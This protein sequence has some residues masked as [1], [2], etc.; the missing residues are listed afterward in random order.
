MDLKK[1][2]WRIIFSVSRRVNNAPNSYF[3]QW[4]FS[5]LPQT[6]TPI[7]R[8][9]RIHC[10]FL[11]PSVFPIVPS[12]H[13]HWL[14]S[15]LNMFWFSSLFNSWTSPWITLFQ[16]NFCRDLLLLRSHLLLLLWWQLR[17]SCGR[18][19]PCRRCV[20]DCHWRLPSHWWFEWHLHWILQGSWWD[21]GFSW[22]PALGFWVRVFWWDLLPNRG[23][24]WIEFQG[25][26]L[27]I[28]KYRLK[29]LWRL[30]ST[31]HWCTSKFQVFSPP[32]DCT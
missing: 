23:K 4:I 5:S 27:R 1:F 8:F 20:R 31:G 18:F 14:I 17:V 10:W 3:P 21:W 29:N 15:P 24:G 26:T 28:S 9:Y 16:G 22:W 25:T 12:T 7:F 6:P 19:A 32:P 2:H 30:F 11:K 13:N